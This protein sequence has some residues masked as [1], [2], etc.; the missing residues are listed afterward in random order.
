MP[1]HPRELEG[2]CTDDCLRE[3]GV[4]T[5]VIE[6]SYNFQNVLAITTD[7]LK[8]WSKNLM[9]HISD[10][11]WIFHSHFAIVLVFCF[12]FFLNQ[13]YSI[14]VKQSYSEVYQKEKPTAACCGAYASLLFWYISIPS[15]KPFDPAIH[16][17]YCFTQE[18]FLT[19]CLLSLQWSEEC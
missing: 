5:K 7:P 15:R 9:V 10:V 18:L 19:L 4:L 8:T 3:I 17:C 14:K 13:G 12:C 6:G 1:K 11:N 16:H 2:Y